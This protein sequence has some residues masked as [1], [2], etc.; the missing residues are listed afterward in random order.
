M[1]PRC[2]RQHPAGPASG[3]PG[4]GAASLGQWGQSRAALGTGE[5]PAPP[6]H[7]SEMIKQLT[8][9]ASNRLILREVPGRRPALP[10]TCAR[11]HR[12]RLRA[13]ALT[14][15]AQIKLVEGQQRCHSQFPLAGGTPDLSAT[16]N[17]CSQDR[18]EPGAPTLPRRTAAGGTQ[19]WV[20]SP[21]R[22]GTKAKLGLPSSVS[23]P[24]REQLHHRGRRSG[25]R[26]SPPRRSRCRALER[27]THS[28]ATETGGTAAGG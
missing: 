26:L 23:G 25:P 20:C 12:S 7:L 24:T 9:F 17:R 11:S 21:A 8:R 13:A 18:D 14:L 16:Q 28:I 27:N 15:A 10:A 22:T 6:G 4:D 1:P 2:H 3:A 5:L 19:L